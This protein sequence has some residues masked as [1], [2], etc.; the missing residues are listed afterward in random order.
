M[1]KIKSVA[2]RFKESVTA[3]YAKHPKMFG[4]AVIII[5]ILVILEFTVFHFVFE[6][7]SAGSPQSLTYRK[8]DP[9]LKKLAD[10]LRDLQN[11]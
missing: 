6:G 10:K 5:V 9:G 1:D 8:T 4:L 2:T 3:T 7:F 11:Q